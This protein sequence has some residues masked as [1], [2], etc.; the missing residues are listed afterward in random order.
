[1]SHGLFYRCI[2][3][4]CGPGNIS[5]VLLSVQGQ[6]ALWFHQKY[7][8]LCSEDEWRS[9]GFGT[10]WGW[11]IND[12][13]FILGWTIPLSSSFFFF[14]FLLNLNYWKLFFTFAVLV[15]NNTADYHFWKCF[16]I[17]IFF[18]Y[19]LF[20]FME[21]SRFLQFFLYCYCCHVHQM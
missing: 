19:D 21:N 9:Y 17:I 13:I 16:F 1:M 10:T 6:R 18:I 15:N 3:C 8:H 11:V 2:Y 5:V 12:R 20:I 14:F 4:V 7:L